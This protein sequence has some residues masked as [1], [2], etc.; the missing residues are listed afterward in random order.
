MAHVEHYKL[1]DIK[2]IEN[3]HI[4]DGWEDKD[5]RIDEDKT[6]YN[7]IL[8]FHNNTS[9][10]DSLQ[11]RLSEVKHSTRKDLN[12]IS[13]WVVT[14]P[15]ELLD[16]P[17]KVTRFFEMTMN[18]VGERYGEDNVLCAYVHMDE[19]TPHMHICIVPV[20]EDTVS[21]KR[22]YNRQELR[23]FHKSLD[24]ECERTFGMPNLCLNGRT[25]GNYTVKELRER[26]KN[27]RELELSRKRLS[28]REQ[29]ITTKGNDINERYQ[30]VQRVEQ[31]ARQKLEDARRASQRASEMLYK[32]R[33]EADSIKASAEQ[34]ASE[35]TLEARKKADSMLSELQS[36][37]RQAV[38]ERNQKR[39]TDG[40]QMANNIQRTHTDVV[41]HK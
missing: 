15:K 3:E 28:K 36:D 11:K 21:A 32:A 41:K 19:T 20:V 35:I 17:D 33:E 23:D 27:E 5:Y 2:R 4:R 34:K 24:Y 25:K 39:Q 7:Y 8:S 38:I 31:E 37:I 9:L 6:K 29:D 40:E 18:F 13:E 1:S 30:M 10:Y 22:L 26:T 14:C 12:V 16:D